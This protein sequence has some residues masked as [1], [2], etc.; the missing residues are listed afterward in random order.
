MI[1]RKRSLIILFVAVLSTLAFSTSAVIAQDTSEGCAAVDGISVSN[2]GNP[3]TIGPAEFFADE[4]IS[5]TVTGGDLD[6]TFDVSINGSP[7]STGNVVGNTVTYTIL[8]DGEYTIVITAS[9][10][11]TVDVVIDVSCEPVDG[12]DDDDNDGGK[13][14]ICH[15]PPGNPDNAKTLTVGA[16]AVP[17][18]LAHGDTIGACSDEIESE[19]VDP[20]DNLII[21]VLDE[22]GIVVVTGDCDED[23][24]TTLA[25]IVLEE[26]E[27]VDGGEFPFDDD[28]TDQYNIIVFY[29][30]YQ[31]RDG[32][33]EFAQVY[34]INI[35]VEGEVLPFNDNV[36]LLQKDDGTWLW[37]TNSNSNPIE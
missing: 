15:Y 23:G 33:G 16:P 35:Y 29:L 22:T 28:P 7:V 6:V 30:G 2:S 37:D 31:D 24:C 18:H 11:G 14:T 5:I 32:D 4:M 12:D 20:E 1:L 36:L 8:E 17:A 9:S 10:P 27:P 34:Q 3:F 26:L 13:V 19:F 25:T 21:I